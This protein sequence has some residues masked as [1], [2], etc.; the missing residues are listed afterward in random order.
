MIATKRPVEK[1]AFN[2][3]NLIL[4]LILAGSLLS[5]QNAICQE[6]PYNDSYTI[7]CHNCYEKK[8][9]K[10]LE[11]A[12]SYTPSIELD[13][14]DMPLLFNHSPMQ[15][16]WYV[17]HSFLQKG[18]KNNFGG[19]LASCFA[20]IKEWSNCNPDHTVLT[21]FIDKKQGWSGA[22][23]S[24]RP[25]DLDD[26]ILAT[27]GKD[28]VYTPHD[29]AGTGGD[30]RTALK[31]NNWASLNSLK[32]KLIFIIT[33]AT[34]FR[35]RNTVLNKYLNKA[36]E[37]AVCFVAP[38]IK[39]KEEIN[40]PSGIKR[41]N[42]NNVVFYNLNYKNCGICEYISSNGFVNRVFKAPETRAEVNDLTGKKV[43]FVAMYNYKLNGR[44]Y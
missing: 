17:K 7:A 24:R 15:N 44:L 12:L 30:L 42:V 36:G 13:I 16:D 25:Q 14:W 23:G 34:F 39:K 10:N 5:R 35:P 28:K 33:D 22:N 43:N 6:L 9:S 41:L 3:N 31:Q 2:T 11:E 21:I 18:N 26:L 38:T 4:I 1:T 29:F 19:S 20:E 40:S 37:N 27:F 8:F 32:G